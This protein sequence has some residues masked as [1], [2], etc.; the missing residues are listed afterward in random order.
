MTAETAPINIT[1]VIGNAILGGEMKRGE[2][3]LA[4]VEVKKDEVR[5]EEKKEPVI[6]NKEEGEEEKKEEAEEKQEEKPEEV[7]LPDNIDELIV[8]KYKEYG[9][10][11][12]GEVQAI[13]EDYDV[14]AKENETLKKELETSKNQPQL[15]ENQKKLFD[16]V[17]NFDGDNAKA[18]AEFTY[19]QSLDVSKLTDREAL[20]ELYVRNSSLDKQKAVRLFERNYKLKYEV[21]EDA[22][23]EDIELAKYSEEEDAQIA[24]KELSK[25]KDQTK[26][27]S[28]AKKEEPQ[29]DFDKNF[30]EI[31]EGYK[32]NFDKSITDFKTLDFKQSFG[33]AVKYELSPEDKEGVK[34]AIHAFIS[35]KNNYGKDGKLNVDMDRLKVQ[36]AF[37]LNP[38]K[39]LDVISKEYFK[40][41]EIKVRKEYSGVKPTRE[42]STAAPA[43]KRPANVLE[44]IGIGIMS[45]K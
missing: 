24:R 16:F 37:A 14:L 28:V 6:E 13:L 4:P 3:V 18:L 21:P 33:E 42:T 25:L 43:G 30:T 34:S 22:S 9:I 11:N 32:K 17:K 15:D 40:Q 19:L 45:K 41:G 26:L 35:N 27:E 2:P 29:S 20:Q 23:A 38:E 12:V 39:I 5:E 10:E 7:K 8:S 31:S 1:D 36:M 44:A